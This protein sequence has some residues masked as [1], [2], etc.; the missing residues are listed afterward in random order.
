MSKRGRRRRIHIQVTPVILK[1]DVISREDFEG[2]V[3]NMALAYGVK[4]EREN[5]GYHIR[6]WDQGG[7]FRI[8]GHMGE[9]FEH[10]AK[11]YG[12]IVQGLAAKR[13]TLG[14]K[15]NA[16]GTPDVAV[17]TR[18]TSPSLTYPAPV[19]MTMNVLFAKY[20]V[21]IYMES[22]RGGIVIYVEDKTGWNV[23]ARMV[24]PIYIQFKEEN[25]E[26]LT[27]NPL[28]YLRKLRMYLGIADLP[29]KS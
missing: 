7:R 23:V 8:M 1:E 14:Y 10:L 20:K 19:L 2:F 26:L 18:I 21:G 13:E 15:K 28:E 22:F 3:N 25:R 16:N 6:T 9:T 29:T 4:P 24:D 11:E 12:G 5:D 27:K 17:C